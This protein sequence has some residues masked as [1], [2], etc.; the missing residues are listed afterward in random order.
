MHVNTKEIPSWTFQSVWWS[1][2]P[3]KGIYAKDR[4]ALSKAKGPWAHYLLTD[5]YDVPVVNGLVA[6]AVNPY[7]EGVSH[8]VATSCRNCHVRS[9][10]TGASY[11]NKDC[12]N[13]L[14]DISPDGQCLKGIIRTDYSWII[15]DRSK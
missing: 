7:I 6:K 11:Q 8:P 13:L 3:N 1:D 14:K 9:G 5:S 2:T 4:P 15:P 12:P 10:L